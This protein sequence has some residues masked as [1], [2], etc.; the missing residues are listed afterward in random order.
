MNESQEAVAC[1]LF[2]AEHHHVLLIKRRD[3]P[4]WVLPGGG[5]DPGETPE[6]AACREMLEETGFAVRITRKIAVYSPLNRLSKTTHFFQVEPI[7]GKP[8][9]GAETVAVT[10]FS[11]ERLPKPMPPPYAFWI[12]DATQNH[13][14]ILHKPVEG[15]SYWMFVKLLFKHPIL[16]LR[17]LL[18]KIGIHF[19]KN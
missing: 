17:F 1:I 16:M 2:S 4:V 19:N 11:L 14:H 9:T 12:A 6:A 18:T 3:I 7:A 5:I 10:F 13:P 8:T 15:T